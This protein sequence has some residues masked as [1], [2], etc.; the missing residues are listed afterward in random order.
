MSRTDKD[1]PYRILEQEA[2][3]HGY[4]R[5]QHT[6]LGNGRWAMTPD[7]PD[8]ATYAHTQGSKAHIPAGDRW[9]DWRDYELDWAP[10]YGSP[11]IIRNHLQQTIHTANSGLMDEDWDDPVLYQR[12]VRWTCGN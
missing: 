10:D 2:R 5:L 7:A 11:T 6:Y 9:H 8:V 3:N 1:K 12:R 4:L